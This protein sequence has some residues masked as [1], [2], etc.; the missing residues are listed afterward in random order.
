[1]PEL[2]EDLRNDDRLHRA[3]V[4]GKLEWSLRAMARPP[5]PTIDDDQIVPRP[6]ARDLHGTNSSYG[7]G[8]S[9]PVKKAF[10]VDDRTTIVGDPIGT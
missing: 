4:H 5:D 10:S 9:R 2:V 1:M 3:R 8:M 6:E 7:G